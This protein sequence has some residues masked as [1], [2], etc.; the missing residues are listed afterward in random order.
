MSRIKDPDECPFKY[1]FCPLKHDDDPPESTG[2]IK[3]LAAHK[4]APLYLLLFWLSGYGAGYFHTHWVLTLVELV[5]S[6]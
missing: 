6:L 1:P 2:I 3:K 5:V 4:W